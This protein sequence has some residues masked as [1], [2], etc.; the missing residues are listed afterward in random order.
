MQKI[1]KMVFDKFDLSTLINRGFIK[2]DGSRTTQ[3]VTAAVC[4]IYYFPDNS[5][6]NTRCF[7]CR[8][9]QCIL[10]I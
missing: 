10:Q 2:G 9:S 7:G 5:N 4:D 1:K 3:Q 6:E 8:L